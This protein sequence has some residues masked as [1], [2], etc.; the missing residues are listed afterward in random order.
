[1][2]YIYILPKCQDPLTPG[3]RFDSRYIPLVRKWGT[4]TNGFGAQT[5]PNT[6]NP[7]A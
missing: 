5:W 6:L 7:K 4:S 1:M 2:G 3:N